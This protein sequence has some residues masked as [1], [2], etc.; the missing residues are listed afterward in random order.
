[1][2]PKALRNIGGSRD[3][4]LKEDFLRGRHVLRA[5]E[6]GTACDD[7]EILLLRRTLLDESA[8]AL[9]FINITLACQFLKGLA[10]G[11]TAAPIQVTHLFFR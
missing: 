9:N 8:L 5:D 10:D 2:Q 3:D 6:R 1:M 4:S 11:Q 7:R